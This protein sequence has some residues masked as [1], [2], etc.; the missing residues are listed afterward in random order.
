MK[1]LLLADPSSS[2][3]IK[4]ANALF[5]NGMD[6]FLFGLS[7]FDPSPYDP[8]I[9][10]ESLKT[11]SFIKSRLNGNILKSVYVTKLPALK[12][13]IKSFKP[14]ILHSHYAASY[15]FLGALTGFHPFINSVWGIDISIFPNVS[16]LH[17]NIIKYT[18]EK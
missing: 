6:V 17:R 1:I 13:V 18:L 11:P 14:D 7:E 16:F 15:G 10:I 2:H 12:R 8:D 5:E 4:W 3:T 9:K